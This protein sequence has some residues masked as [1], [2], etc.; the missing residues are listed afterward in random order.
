MRRKN[1]WHLS[2][3]KLL[4]ACAC[5]IAALAEA[6][7][8]ALPTS[9]RSPAP[10]LPRVSGLAPKDVQDRVNA[11]LA[12]REKEDRA[13]RRDCL[14]TYPPDFKSSF[15]ETVRLTYLSSDLLSVDIR[16]SWDGCAAYPNIDM[17][18]PLTIDLIRGKALDWEIFF[19]DGFLKGTDQ[20]SPLTAL[21]LGH[22]QLDEDCSKTVSDWATGYGPGYDLWLSKRQ[23]LMI[24]PS[25]PHVVRACAVLV[26]TPFT[27]IQD[28]IRDET[29]RKEFLAVASR[30]K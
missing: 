1:L 14:H 26:S 8:K 25:L 17:P 23:G 6:H 15:A 21:Y 4:A 18:E 27:E 9:S 12:A 7:I 2:L 13:S 5:C 24:E 20:R 19:V 11:L 16:A 22:A 30:A 10:T 3:V 29:I 28:S